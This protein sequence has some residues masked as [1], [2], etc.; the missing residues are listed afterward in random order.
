MEVN[1]I[2]EILKFSVSGISTVFVFLALM[3]VVL[4]PLV[5]SIIKYFP[6][7]EGNVFISNST[8]GL[9]QKGNFSVVAAVAASIRS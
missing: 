2:V 7:Y 4:V 3:A 1:L 8:Q 5:K 9:F 6:L